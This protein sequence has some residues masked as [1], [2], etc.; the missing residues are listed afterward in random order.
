MVK[1]FRVA[2]VGGEGGFGTDG[3]GITLGMDRVPFFAPG[4]GPDAG[5]AFAEEG[6]ARR[7]MGRA[8]SWATVSN[9][10]PVVKAFHRLGADAGEFT[11]G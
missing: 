1:L 2:E 4:H 3:L 8:A 11:G 10:S 6:D 7:L 5:G 9:I